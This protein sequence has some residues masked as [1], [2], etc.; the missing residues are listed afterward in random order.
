MIRFKDPIWLFLLILPLGYVYMR[1]FTAWLRPP[2]LPYSNI[3]VFSGI[4]SSWRTR[5]S[6]SLPILK[7][8]GLSALIHA[9]ARPQSGFGETRESVEGVDIMLALDISSSMKAVYFKPK[10]R[11]HVA[12]EVFQKFI[13]EPF[14]L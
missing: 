8:V 6:S 5:I 1:Y 13:D 11:L 4:A 14:R 9:M 3:N 7:A 12:K 2:S 10:N